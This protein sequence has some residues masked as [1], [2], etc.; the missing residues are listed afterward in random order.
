MK[1]IAIDAGASKTRV[2]KSDTSRA[3]RDKEIILNPC[4]YL[5][6]GQR[7]IKE[8][9][10]SI[11]TKFKIKSPG[12]YHVVAGI[13]GA[14]TS[15]SKNRIQRIFGSYGFSSDRT[16]IYSDAELLIYSIGNDS[17]VLIAGTGSICLGRKKL[18]DGGYLEAKAGGYGYRFNSEPGGYNLA[19][20]AIGK[21]L[22]IEDGISEKSTILCDA[23]KHL[24]KVKNL[25]CLIPGIYESKNVR[26]LIPGL[27]PL[28]FKS[29]EKKD[30]VSLDL[31]KEHSDILSLYIKAV[32]SKLG[33][34]QATVYLHGGQFKNRLSNRLLIEPV[35]NHRKLAKL[36]LKFK[37]SGVK[38]S[39]KDTL[40]EVVKKLNLVGN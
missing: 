3:A 36:N 30:H 38:K 10:E 5:I 8:I 19:I 37:T 40:V 18:L 17:I 35:K 7:R 16:T 33:L 14:V 34:N 22:E 24:F 11:L 26:E 32:Y 2:I 31:L 21:C 20:K 13:A 15:G 23:I 28:I 12:N 4:N 6:H 25:R 39:D 29:A 27:V 1:I 9:I